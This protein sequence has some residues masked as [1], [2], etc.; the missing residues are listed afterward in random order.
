[1]NK[2]I[3]AAAVPLL[4]RCQHRSVSWL[5]RGGLAIDVMPIWSSTRCYIDPAWSAGRLRR[6][7]ARSM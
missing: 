4:W 5:C 2:T 3:P 1:M 6:V 7:D